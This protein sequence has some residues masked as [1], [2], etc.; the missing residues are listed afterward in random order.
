MP[1]SSGVPDLGLNQEMKGKEADPSHLEY[2]IQ[3]G[4]IDLDHLGLVVPKK[5]AKSTRMPYF[6]LIDPSQLPR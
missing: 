5:I 1:G 6:R 4:I 2:R 3:P